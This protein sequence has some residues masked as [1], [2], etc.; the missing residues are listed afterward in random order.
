[1]IN[2]NILIQ[3]SK[4]KNYLKPE[5]YFKKKQKKIN[6]LGFFKRRN[7]EITINLSNT[8]EVRKLNNKF[9]GKNKSTD[10]LAFPFLNNNSNLIKNKKKKYL[11]D[12]IINLS[13]IKFKDNKLSFLNELDKLWIHGLLHLCGYKHKKQV[14]YEKMLRKE[15]IYL[16]ALQ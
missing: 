9:R 11:G 7:L 3:D 2:I 4:W 8:K 10:V 12:I 14:D 13:K 16:N 1:M 15:Y 5:I 6:K